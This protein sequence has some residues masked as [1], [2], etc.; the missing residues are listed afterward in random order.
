MASSPNS[1]FLRLAPELRNAIYYAALQKCNQSNRIHIWTHTHRSHWTPPALLQVNHQIRHETIRL[2]Y[3]IGIF[4][5]PPTF[6][7]SSFTLS[8]AYLLR[9][10]R[11]LGSEAREGLRTVEIDDRVY[12]DPEAMAAGL[13]RYSLL[14]KTAGC[15][16]VAG[17]LAVEMVVP[18]PR[19]TIRAYSHSVRRIWTKEPMRDH[20]VVFAQSCDVCATIRRHEDGHR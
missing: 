13:A 11:V 6:P 3:S 17:I 8:I 1:P 16:L 9:W 19:A 7:A 15:E 20:A 5:L 4:R 14:L 10:L 12:E 2:Y 18:C